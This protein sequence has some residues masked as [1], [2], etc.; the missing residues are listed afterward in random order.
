MRWR[1]GLQAKLAMACLLGVAVAG[2]GS[3]SSG[4]TPD[5]VTPPNHEPTASS[6]FVP[7][8]I[9]PGCGHPHAT[10]TLVTTRL[11]VTISHTACDLRGVLIRWRNGSDQVPGGSAAT[12]ATTCSEPSTGRLGCPSVSVAEPSGDVTIRPVD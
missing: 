10:V 11:P 5:Q 3:H 6:A 7:R 12:D 4:S 2:C 1:T 9:R 8:E